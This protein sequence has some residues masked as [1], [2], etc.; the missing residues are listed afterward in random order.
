MKRLLLAALALFAWTA[1]D[2][3]T[4][5]NNFV[6][7]QT[8]NVGVVQFLQGTDSAGTYK[9]IYTAGA[10][11][12]KCYGGYLTSND[13]TSHLVT[14]QLVRS[15]V[16]YGGMAINTGTTLPGFANGVPPIAFMSASNWPG[17]PTDN[18]NNPYILMASGDTLQA[19]FATSLTS[20]DFISAVVICGDF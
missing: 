4:T 9:T 3:A 14:F 10:N 12:S 2:A 18:A 15:S 19:T 13:S 17:L 11:G 8:P 16:K 5:G 7:E 6:T 20:S 1:A